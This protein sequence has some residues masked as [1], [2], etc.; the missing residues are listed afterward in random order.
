MAL[1]IIHTSFVQWK[2]WLPTLES[3]E[4][5]SYYRRICTARSRRARGRTGW[6]A[7]PGHTTRSIRA[8]PSPGSCW[9]PWTRRGRGWCRGCR[10]PWGRHTARSGGSS[11]HPSGSSG[12][13]RWWKSSWWRI[14]FHVLWYYIMYPLS[15]T[16]YPTMRPERN[17]PVMIK[18]WWI[19][20][21]GMLIYKGFFYLLRSR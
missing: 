17:N 8:C 5:T 11:G 2:E 4:K 3:T 19:I 10:P 1:N 18:S 20:S 13:D 21:W 14:T 15:S 9:S 6:A 16:S 7:R 12:R